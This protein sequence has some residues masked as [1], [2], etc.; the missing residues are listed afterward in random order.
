MRVIG[1]LFAALGLSLLA[2]IGLAILLAPGSGDFQ[3]RHAEFVGTFMIDLSAAWRIGS[4]RDRVTDVFAR[5][6]GTPAGRKTLSSF[7]TLG[8]LL[9][10]EHLE[11]RA[12]RASNEETAGLFVFRAVF[13]RADASVRLGLERRDGV[14]RVNLLEISPEGGVDQRPLRVEI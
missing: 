2:L 10:I 14:P 8:R 5:E 12:F 13:E 6:V 9:R 4:V 11:L 3:R 7:R 1:K